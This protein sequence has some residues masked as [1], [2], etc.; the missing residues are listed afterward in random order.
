MFSLFSISR[1]KYEKGQGLVEYAILLTLIA[2]LAIGTIAVLGNKNC[3][4][5]NS[6]NNS[7][8]N[9]SSTGCKAAGTNQTTYTSENAAITA[10][11]AGKPNNTKYYMYVKEI[12][13]SETFI[14]SLTILSPVPLGYS[15]DGSNKCN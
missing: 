5:F 3:N 2:V 10:I 8:G 11:C 15:L 4:T 13:G 14:P 6:I 7:L 9:A 12:G 1:S